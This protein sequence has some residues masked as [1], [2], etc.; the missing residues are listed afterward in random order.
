MNEEQPSKNVEELLNKATLEQI[1]QHAE[2]LKSGGK[3]GKPLYLIR[4][5]LGNIPHKPFRNPDSNWDYFFGS[6]FNLC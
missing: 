2:W 3:L 6:D 1:Q 4:T 5:D